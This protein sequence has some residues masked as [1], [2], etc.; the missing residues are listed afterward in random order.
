MSAEFHIHRLAVVQGHRGRGLGQI[1]MQCAL[2]KA[3]SLP[4]SKCRWITLSALNSAVSFYEHFGFV[5]LGCGDPLAEDGQTWM[6]LQNT[7]S[8]A[9]AEDD[10]DTTTVDNDEGD[11]SLLFDD[12]AD[13]E[14]QVSL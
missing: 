4:Q 14:A 6:E 8:S 9:A 12:E 13:V 2:A 3:A 11:D 7:S 1:L 5:D 10:D